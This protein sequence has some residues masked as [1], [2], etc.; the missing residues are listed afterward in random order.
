MDFDHRDPAD[1]SFEVPRMLGR[2]TTQVLLE[3]V[4]KCDIVCANCH[5]D[6]TYRWHAA[7]RIDV[8]RE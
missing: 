5:R 1:K 2:V 8:A 4:S 7:D 6:R 3:E